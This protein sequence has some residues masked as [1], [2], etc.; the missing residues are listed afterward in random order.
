MHVHRVPLSR[1]AGVIGFAIMAAGGF[2]AAAAERT[3][4]TGIIEFCANL[5][6]DEQSAPTY[7]N[8]VGRADFVLQRSDL[9]FSWKIT[10]SGLTSRPLEANL[11]APQRIG[12]NTGVQFALAKPPVKSPINGSLVLTGGQVEYLLTGRMYVNITTEKYKDGELRAQIQRI[13]PGDKCP[14]PYPPAR[15]EVNTPKP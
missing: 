3:A 5:S 14:P 15:S 8:G 11:H 13:R 6:P 4:E 7:S 9:K 1:A 10:F 12:S 2:Q